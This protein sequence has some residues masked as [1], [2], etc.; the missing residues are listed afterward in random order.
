MPKLVDEAELHKS[1][2]DVSLS[3]D[4]NG[5]D[6]PPR[7][8]L[9]LEYAPSGPQ[10]P[11]SKEFMPLI[12]LATPSDDEVTLAGDDRML[13]EAIQ[14]EKYVQ[15]TK[16]LH[17]RS[18]EFVMI[19]L[20]DFRIYRPAAL[21]GSKTKTNRQ[22]ELEPLHH[23]K[24]GTG[25]D[26]L[27]FD[28]VISVGEVQ[29]YIEG[30]PFETVAVEG[31]GDTSMHSVGQHISIQ[32]R[33]AAAKD[34]WYFLETPSP[35]YLS[36]HRPFL[37]V[38]HF[39]KHVIDYIAKHE[40]LSDFGRTDFRQAV[41][42]YTEYLIK[43]SWAVFRGSLNDPLWADI[44]FTSTESDS[45][46][47]IRGSEKTLLTPYV[48]ESFRH[49]SPL[50][51]FFEVHKPDKHVE[52]AWNSRKDALGFIDAQHAQDLA[53]DEIITKGDIKK[54]DYIVVRPDEETI[55][56]D[57][58]QVW[59]AFV[60]NV[61]EDRH[62]KLYEVIWL[63]SPFATTLAGGQAKPNELDWTEEFVKISPEAVCSRRSIR[64]FQD[65][66]SIP[67]PHSRNGI[68]NCW[69]ITT[70]ICPSGE[71]EKL[72][73]PFPTSLNEG[74][75][76]LTGSPRSKM[77]GLD[78]F[79]GGGN[80]GR[81]LE[82]GGAVE[83]LYAIDWERN[84][85][86]TYKANQSNRHPCWVH[87]GS[88]NDYLQMVLRGYKGY[89]FAMI[90]DI[91]FIA[92]G[93]PCQGFSFL[94]RDK[95]SESSLRN[96]SMVASVA[97][98]VDLYRPKYALLENVVAMANK[99]K[100][101][102]GIFPQLLCTLVGLGYQVSQHFLD[103]SSFGDSQKRSRLFISITAPGLVPMPPPTLTHSHSPGT[104]ARALGRN[105]AN[106]LK[107]GE[108]RFGP[109]PFKYVSVEESMGDLP[110]VGDSHI[111]TCIP[112]PDHRTVATE[113]AWVRQF[114]K[115]IPI[116]PSGKSAMD[117]ILT[118]TMPSSEPNQEAYRGP[119]FPGM[120]FTNTITTAPAGACAINGR[121]L[122]W[123]QH[124]V[125]T[126]REARRAQGFDEHDVITGSSSK[127]WKIIGNSVSRSV[128][129][130]LGM[131]LQEAWLANP[132]D[133]R[134]LQGQ[135]PSPDGE[136]LSEQDPVIQVS[137]ESYPDVIAQLPS[138]VKT[139]TENQ[140]RNSTRTISN[141]PAKA[142]ATA[143]RMTEAQIPRLHPRQ[144]HRVV[145]DLTGD[146]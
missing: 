50:T 117:S 104:S 111:Q 13:S 125:L 43:E 19:S 136:S 16:G 89:H 81:G 129:L 62:G 84:A 108:R 92:A 140:R 121:V 12:D 72:Y 130:G 99:G 94:Q 90:G 32:S 95:T 36:Y 55:W 145:I 10:E 20:R 143:L 116:H 65:I 83:F 97:A 25:C 134:P 80:F 69:F 137:R 64:F 123:Q 128:A 29:H 26:H 3:E 71:L 38:A 23:L 54:N 4:D 31:Y 122:H 91:D 85:V 61:R 124:R 102:L 113:A 57:G 60:Q 27:L 42:S 14:R 49:I 107:F 133:P 7:K 138:P 37:W 100:D 146:D 114:I 141:S 15:K 18:D 9:K 28:G 56:K 75:D 79:D 144:R 34:I 24:T 67:P 5:G 98:Y 119:G 70:R 131:A 101:K 47:E 22:L 21:P 93:S 112:Y 39:A 87:W 135:L 33:A 76:T 45:K 2:A 73:P 11:G 51:R 82:E 103:A 118:G 17:E 58:S 68:G 63:Y 30:V 139:P 1:F 126:I 35:E 77:I 96:I 110:D 44:S 109:T 74:L 78:A 88:V 52:I 66:D 142:S 40:K 86:L 48:F 8:R 132:P 59:Y 115:H 127:Q 120:D 6:G 41:I 46:T 53:L 105:L 106:D